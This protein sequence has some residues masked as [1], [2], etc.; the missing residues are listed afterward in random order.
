MKY[1]ERNVV[2][3][4]SGSGSI[5]IGVA[6]VNNITGNIDKLD[7]TAAPIAIHLAKDL[8]KQTLVA[9]IQ[10]TGQIQNLYSA[11]N[12]TLNLCDVINPYA[13]RVAIND[14][15]SYQYGNKFSE[16]VKDRYI[17]Y[18]TDTVKAIKK[19]D[20]QHEVEVCLVG[21]AALRKA[22]DGQNLINYLDQRLRKLGVKT[23]LKIISQEEEGIYAFDGAVNEK[24][25]D[26]RHVISFDIGGGSMQLTGVEG[27]QHE[28]LGGTVAS[29]TFNQSVMNAL[30]VKPG[31]SI[32]P[33]NAD[34]IAEMIELGKEKLNFAAQQEL[35]LADKMNQADTKVVGLGNIHSSLLNLMQHYKIYL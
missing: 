17:K 19:L 33:L 3:I 29:A 35:W 10:N 14:S 11:D 12:K 18:L 24:K 4:D 32:Y 7:Y 13:D 28:V 30:N 27:N 5:K 6:S 31:E 34:K 21:T 1:I 23:N 26:N 16:E 15:L 20:S 2:A 8:E 25:L 22:D 9:E